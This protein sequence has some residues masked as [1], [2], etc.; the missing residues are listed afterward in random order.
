MLGHSVKETYAILSSCLRMAL[1]NLGIDSQ[2]HDS[3][4]LFN[5]LKRQQKLPCFLAPNRD[6]VM[7]DGKKLIGSAQRRTAG[8]VL[9]HGSLP[10]SDAYQRLPDYLNISEPERELQKSLLRRKTINLSALDP[11]IT[12]PRV[13]KA[14]I[15]GFL[16]VLQISCIE[17]PW[18]AAELDIILSN[19]DL[20]PE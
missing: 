4:Q 14:I 19:P 10:I 20:I 2:T 13:S 16:Q 11:T 17:Q 9:Q 6:E 5:Q 1:K 7:V 15:E 3:D 8:A 18:S 12:Y